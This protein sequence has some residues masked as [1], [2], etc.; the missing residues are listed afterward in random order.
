[1][2]NYPADRIKRVTPEGY[3][4]KTLKDSKNKISIKNRFQKTIFR[5]S[6]K[7]VTQERYSKTCELKKSLF[8]RKSFSQKTINKSYQWGNAGKI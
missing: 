5:R 8:Y 3:E 1:M 4:E 6:Y 2:N 7:Y